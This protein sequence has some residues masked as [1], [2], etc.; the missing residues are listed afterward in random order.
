VVTEPLARV[1][2]RGIE[3]ADGTLVE[4]DVIIYATGFNL[5]F[6][7][8]VEIVGRGGA[9]LAEQWAGGTDPRSYLGGTVPNFPNL[10]VT[11]GP[12]SSSGHGGGHNFMT[13]VVVHYITECLRLLVERGARSLEVRQEVQDE[14]IAA[15]DAQMEGSIWRNSPKAHT[16]YR[17]PSG[18][19][20]LPNPWRM[21]DY[22]RMSRTPDESRFIVR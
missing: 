16:Y 1:T 7:S 20:I 14:F 5:E 15:V 2:P 6:L 19:V 17:N 9:R 21:V 12:N 11:S 4:L 18:R 8:P 3:T 10:F 13:E 22:W